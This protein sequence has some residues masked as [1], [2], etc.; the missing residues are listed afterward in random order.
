MEDEREDYELEELDR[1]SI[2]VRKSVL[3]TLFIVSVLFLVV[4]YILHVFNVIGNLT[5]FLLMIPAILI[6]LIVILILWKK[7]R[8]D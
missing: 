7:G 8:R 5:M 2:P 1:L 4:P 3:A 6:T